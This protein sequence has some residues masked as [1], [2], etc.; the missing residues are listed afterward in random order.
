MKK[1]AILG[2]IWGTTFSLWASA[3]TINRQ[4][5]LTWTAPTT[6]DGGAALTQCP[7]LGYSV[8]KLINGTWTQIG[9]TA[10]SVLTYTDSNLPVGIHTY[11]VL[12]NSEAGPSRPSNE[13]SKPLN[14]PGAPGNLVITVT[15]TIAE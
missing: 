8:Q 2:V 5:R 11:R 14:V 7:I 10:A 1:L 3:Q 6:C 13:V 12:T 15:V 9:V 4:A